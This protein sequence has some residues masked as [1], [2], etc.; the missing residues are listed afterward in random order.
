MTVVVRESLGSIS[1]PHL[2]AV[3]LA[4]LAGAASGVI[5]KRAPSAHPVAMNAVGMA[6]GV[7]ILA[8]AS[9]VAREPWRLPRLPETWVALGRLVMSAAVAFILFVW[10]IR[11]WSAS[12]ASY[13]T[14][15]FPIVT[16][17]VASSLVDE[18]VAWS[19]AAGA[20]LVGAGVYL[21]ALAPR[22]TTQSRES[23]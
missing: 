23:L 12:A 3:F 19:L 21:G 17:L 11:R 18:P 22:R 5:V 15:L 7:V 4:A 6:T 10:L 14:V 2:I 8:G 1:R 20:A 13:T 16:I 9:R